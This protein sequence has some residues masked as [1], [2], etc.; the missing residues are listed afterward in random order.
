ME[1]IS[2]ID[3]KTNQLF[4]RG[5][6]AVNLA[7]STD[8]ESV[9]FLLVQG[10]LPTDS[11]RKN[12]IRSMNQLRKVYTNEIQSL[13]KLIDNLDR[14]REEHN[15]DLHDTLLAFVALCPLVIANQFTQSK[16]LEMRNPNDKL[17]HAANILWMTRETTQ[18]E[19]DIK[20][21]QTA[22]ILPMDDPDNP[23]LSALT[24]AL[25]T[26]NEID[27]LH[28]A[29]KKHVGPLHHGAGKLAM[30]MFEEI[31]E[32]NSTRQYL[33]KRV[34]S[35]GKIYGLGHRIYRGF[36]PRAVVLRDMLEK[37]TMNTEGEWILHVS[38]VVAEEGGKL[39]AS[40][41][42]IKAYPNIDLYNAAVYSTLGFPPEWNTSLFAISRAAGWMAH[43]LELVQ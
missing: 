8:Y 32:P 26:G 28:A 29:L 34:A 1:P 27:A 37:R 31:K 11:Q 30:E 43:I 39:L 7:E 5:F 25:E 10:N 16:D 4:F 20:D 41:K 2:R 3:P 17:G 22:L 6:N 33:E 24:D 21:L 14:F 36:D 13:D 15:L 19:N 38:E 35:G 18:I 9:L 23:S 40:Q 42:G 12:L